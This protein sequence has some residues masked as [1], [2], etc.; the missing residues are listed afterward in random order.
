MTSADT[1]TNAA[2]SPAYTKTV[3]VT[4]TFPKTEFPPV[5]KWVALSFDDALSGAG[6]IRLLSILEDPEFKDANHPN[7]V[8]ATWFIL[9]ENMALAATAGSVLTDTTSTYNPPYSL[10]TEQQDAILRV[11]TRGDNLG[12]HA[13]NHYDWTYFTK[14]PKDQSSGNISSA[15]HRISGMSYY[16]GSVA[17]SISSART[18]NAAVMAR[19]FQ[20]NRQ[21]IVAMTTAF[22]YGGTAK[23]AQFFRHPYNSFST[24]LN[25]IFPATATVVGTGWTFSSRSYAG[26]PAIE[27]E[28][29]DTWDW[30]NYAMPE[31]DW[32]GTP[33]DMIGRATRPLGDPLGGLAANG[34]IYLM[35]DWWYETTGS[36]YNTLT[37]NSLAGIIRELRLQG[38]GFKTIAD[39]RQVRYGSTAL[40][41]GKVYDN[42]VSSSPVTLTRVKE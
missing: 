42:F 6:T 20:R 16:T 31:A 21:M 25:G 38:Y 18:A 37:Y 34:Q 24:D 26:I 36:G 22:G 10:T 1:V 8:P 19:D 13:F 30:A 35:H 11:T 32:A 2:V 39:L 7:G 15:N 4:A 33:A 5:T 12:S 41:A 29:G 40:T 17:S 23:D 9:G 27:S 3:T 14:T 28:S